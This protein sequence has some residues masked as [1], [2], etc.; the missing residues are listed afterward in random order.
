M[1]R[2][3]QPHRSPENNIERNWCSQK[4]TRTTKDYPG[5]QQRSLYQPTKYSGHQQYQKSIKG[6]TSS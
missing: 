4:G 6:P 2:D 3:N 5:K 1:F